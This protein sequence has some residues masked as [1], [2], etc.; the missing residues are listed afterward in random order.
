MALTS[1]GAISLSDIRSQIGGAD[2]TGSISL[3]DTECRELFTSGTAIG[4][5]SGSSISMS[6]FYGGNF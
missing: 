6:D 5:S 1:S 4:G 2:K 3:N